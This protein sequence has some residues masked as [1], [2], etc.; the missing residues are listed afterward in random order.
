MTLDASPARSHPPLHGGDLQRASARFGEPAKGWIDLSTGISP[1]SWPVPSIPER[2]FRRL[3]PQQDGLKQA[4]MRYYQSDA[5]LLAVPGSQWAISNLCHALRSVGTL[6]ESDCVAAPQWGYKEH[7]HAW[8]RA[9]IS[10][11]LY[12]SLEELEALVNRG[13]VQHAVIIDPNNPT[14]E[15]CPPTLLNR[16]AQHL[17][18]RQGWVVVDQAFADL[19]CERL[20]EGPV[21]EPNIVRLRSL[22]KFF[23]LAGLRLGFV[24]A[25]QAILGA[26]EAQL[27][28]WAI[29][30]PTRWI[31]SQALE[32]RDWQNNQRARLQAR[33]LAWSQWLQSKLGIEIRNAQLF[34]TLRGPHEYCHSL[35]ERLG[36]KGVLTRIFEPHR[37][38]NLLRFGVPREEDPRVWASWF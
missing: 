15:G 10:S 32:D 19:R 16:V 9:G 17:H 30:H 29:A 4:A 31:A 6:G 13:E 20:S 7:V 37:G 18:A 24:A 2:V 8:E 34:C 27:G 12:R 35:Y 22:G 21:A 11:T 14:T 33:S 23:G 3:P 36:Y 28:P 5:E 25:P 26:L 38:E 1:W